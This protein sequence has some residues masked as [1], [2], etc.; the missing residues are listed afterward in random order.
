MLHDI[1]HSL[2]V[3]ACHYTSGNLFL[4]QPDV[5]RPWEPEDTDE[6]YEEEE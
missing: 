6:D 1:I 5:Q 4:S 3:V 2:L